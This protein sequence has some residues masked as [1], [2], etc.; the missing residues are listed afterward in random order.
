M[1]KALSGINEGLLKR[2]VYV[3]C[4]EYLDRDKLWDKC[5]SHDSAEKEA[6]AWRAPAVEE[7]REECATLNVC[8]AGHPSV[9]ERIRASL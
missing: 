8:T 3:S 7:E 9:S 5:K 1:R 2:E 4:K 6:Q